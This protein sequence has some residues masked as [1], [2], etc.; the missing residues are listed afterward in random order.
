MT[1]VGKGGIQIAFLG[2]DGAGK[3]TQAGMLWQRLRRAGV[4]A[5]LLTNDIGR[6]IRESLPVRDSDLKSFAPPFCSDEPA[7]EFILWAVFKTSTLLTLQTISEQS[8]AVTVVDRHVACQLATDRLHGTGQEAFLRALNHDVRPPHLSI[9]LRID[10][11]RAAERTRVRGGAGVE[12]ED[13]LRRYDEAYQSLPEYGN[14]EVIDATGPKD[15]VHDAVC[16]V[17]AYRVPLLRQALT[18]SRRE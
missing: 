13:V 1:T 15:Y 14:F 2:I 5:L 10:A 7:P 8:G 18:G 3:T 12:A 6:A 9:Y 4:E 11:R 17:V 16:R